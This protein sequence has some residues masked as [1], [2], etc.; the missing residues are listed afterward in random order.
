MNM[1]DR[2][3][4]MKDLPLLNLPNQSVYSVRQCHI[5]Y[6]GEI[7]QELNIVLKILER[8]FPILTGYCLAKAK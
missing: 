3:L 1:R 2:I 5:L 4:N 6:L 7:I 8:F